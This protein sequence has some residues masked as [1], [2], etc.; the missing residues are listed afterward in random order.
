MPKK[1]IRH[2]G[3][4]GK[5]L[6]Y[7]F[8]KGFF[9]TRFKVENPYLQYDN[10]EL[11]TVDA[12]QHW[13]QENAEEYVGVNVTQPYKTAILPFLDK[14]SPEANEI[15]AVN[16]VLFKAN[17]KIGYN[18][19]AYGFKKSVQPFLRDVHKKALIFGTGGAAKAVDYVLK[20]LGITVAHLSRNPDEE[21]RIYG[22]DQANEQ[23]VKSFPILVN[24]TPLGTFPNVNEQVDFPI[25]LVGKE[26][27]VIDLIY[28]PDE[29][30][31]LK[32]AREQGAETL[33]GLS[34]LKHQALKAWEIWNV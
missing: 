29:T 5:K 3:L 32:T 34:M 17:K 30:Q 16:T 11:P 8:S 28:N 24:C 13:L 2:F 23:M 14:L 1:A 18:T 6:D 7:S 4:I 22:Y 9:D 12:L 10:I 20:N 27:L 15:G 21:N 19:D 26:H 31:L 33:N 25:Q